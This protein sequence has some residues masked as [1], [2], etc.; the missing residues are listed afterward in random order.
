MRHKS[1][2]TIFEFDVNENGVKVK[3]GLTK[4]TDNLMLCAYTTREKSLKKFVWNYIE[5][6]I[7][8][9]FIERDKLKAS[10]KRR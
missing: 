7:E 5:E 8:H 6:R 2:I 4:N 10:A 1:I 3:I 9:T